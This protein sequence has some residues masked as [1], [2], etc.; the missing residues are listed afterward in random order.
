M[1]LVHMGGLGDDLPV[2]NR[3]F[4]GFHVKLLGGIPTPL[5]NDGV[6]QLGLLSPTEWRKKHVP[7]HQPDDIVGYKSSYHHSYPMK[8]K[9][10]LLLPLDTTQ[11]SGLNHIFNHD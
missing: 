7:N 5:K 9:T 3:E 11:M 6:R 10:S 4:F 8:Q 2:G 1:A